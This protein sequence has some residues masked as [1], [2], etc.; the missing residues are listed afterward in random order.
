M[1]WGGIVIAGDATN[2]VGVLGGI[3]CGGRLLGIGG[4]RIGVGL[5]V[6]KLELHLVIVL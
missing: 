3:D 1:V 4:V 6:R 2:D 5:V